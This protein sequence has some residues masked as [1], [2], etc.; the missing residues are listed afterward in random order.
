[1]LLLCL[2]GAIIWW[3]GIRQ[4]RRALNV[5]WDARIG[6]ISWDLHSALGFWTFLFLVVWG[7]SGFYFCFP[8]YVNVLYRLDPGGEIVS[9]ALSWLT[10]LHFGRFNGVTRVLWAIVGVV[11]AVLAFTGFFVCCRRVIFRKNDRPESM[12]FVANRLDLIA[13]L[14]EHPNR[15]GKVTDESTME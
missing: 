15:G 2:T 13:E 8:D 12:A 6:R 4:W 11:P 7:V 14:L 10:D 3:P 1:M 5:K 9:G